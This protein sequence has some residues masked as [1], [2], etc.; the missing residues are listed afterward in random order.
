MNLATVTSLDCYKAAESKATIISCQRK[1][2]RLLARV[3]DKERWAARYKS[4]QMCEAY[5]RDID[6]LLYEIAILEGRVMSN[7]LELEQ[8]EAKRQESETQ[9]LVRLLQLAAPT[10]EPAP[11]PTPPTPSAAPRT[12]QLS[13][14]GPGPAPIDTRPSGSQSAEREWEIEND[15]AVGLQLSNETQVETKS[16]SA[17]AVMAPAS[18]APVAPAAPQADRPAA[19]PT[20]TPAAKPEQAPFRFAYVPSQ[21]AVTQSPAVS[22]SAAGVAVVDTAPTTHRVRHAQARVVGESPET[23][24]DERPLSTKP[25]DPGSSE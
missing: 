10:L 4:R 23:L 21:P 11:A 12:E 25:I 15:I 18:S 13:M 5:D 22:P 1:I 19:A 14:F 6:G 3:A 17:V 20:V 7:E 24:P 2:N 16:E 9:R 8:I